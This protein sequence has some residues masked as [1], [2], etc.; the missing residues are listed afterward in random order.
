MTVGVPVRIL[1]IPVFR[2]YWC[3]HA[4]EDATAAQRL[5]TEATNIEWRKG[6]N[7]EEKLSLLGTK[8]SSI[9]SQPNKAAAVRI[10]MHDQYITVDN[11]YFNLQAHGKIVKQWRSLESAADGTIRNRIFRSE[12]LLQ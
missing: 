9:V 6:A 12:P 10:P 8:L 3:F 2:R 11:C 4:I 1:V 7:L 5:A